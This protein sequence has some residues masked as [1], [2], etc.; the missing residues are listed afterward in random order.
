[1]GTATTFKI[2]VL[3]TADGHVIRTLDS[4]DPSMAATLRVSVSPDGRFVYFDRPAQLL[5]AC[6]VPEVYRVPTRGG[7]RDPVTQGASATPSPNGRFLALVRTTTGDSC[8]T[9]GVIVIRDLRS[10]RERV[11][12][13][14]AA[15]R[16]YRL[17]WA[18]N[19]RDLFYATAD[20]PSP[21][22]SPADVHLDGFIL[23]T[24][25]HPSRPHQ[26]QLQFTKRIDLQGY[27]G[28]SGLLIGAYFPPGGRTQIVGV[29][30]RTLAIR[31]R[32]VEFASGKWGLVN[33]SIDSDPTGN[34]LLFV[35]VD[36]PS[37]DVGPVRWS[38]GD[39]EPTRLGDGLEAAWVLRKH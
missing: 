23:D 30:P 8:G 38:T 17:S 1:M 26:R 14:G 9:T 32:L 12:Q 35:A 3:S 29:D 39:R 21:S 37:G 22:T 5:G 15:G 28:R 36:T 27:L 2:V 18:A 19:S 7:T 4:P 24:R 33:Q 13:G 16:I 6:Y 10:G 34:H 11:F 31:K 25:S 20:A